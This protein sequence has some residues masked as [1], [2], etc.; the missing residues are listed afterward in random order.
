MNRGMAQRRHRATD[1]A[2]RSIDEAVAELDRGEAASAARLRRRCDVSER[3]R[4][5]YSPRATQP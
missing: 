2:L 1:E 3:M 5:V 4:I